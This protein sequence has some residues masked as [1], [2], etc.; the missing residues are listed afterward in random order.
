M[1]QKKKTMNDHLKLMPNIMSCYKKRILFYW[2]QTAKKGHVY[3]KPR[4][5]KNIRNLRKKKKN[6]YI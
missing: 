1:L 4:Q 5:I 2:Q 6:V 3:S